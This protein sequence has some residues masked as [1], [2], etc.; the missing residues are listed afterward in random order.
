MQYFKSERVNLF[1]EWAILTANS[2]DD[3]CKDCI[4]VRGNLC[5]IRKRIYSDGIKFPQIDC[6]D[7]DRMHYR[8]ITI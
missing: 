7:Q 4:F 8:K 5:F 2:Q 1:G 3:Y 6:D